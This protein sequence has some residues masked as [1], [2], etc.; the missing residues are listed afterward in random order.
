MSTFLV[1]VVEIV[2]LWLLDTAFLRVAAYL[3]ARAVYDAHKPIKISDV[4]FESISGPSF[5]PV[6]FRMS[7]VALKLVMLVCSIAIGLSI[8]GFSASQSVV[9]PEQTIVVR[10]DRQMADIGIGGFRNFSEEVLFVKRAVSCSR[11]DR[12]DRLGIR[13]TTFWNIR[14]LVPVSSRRYVLRNST[15]K[16]PVQCLTKDNN[17]NV[18]AVLT[19]NEL[20]ARASCAEKLP[21]FSEIQIGV[22]N[23]SISRCPWRLT[24]LYCQAEHRGGCAFTLDYRQHQVL[25]MVTYLNESGTSHGSIYTAWQR[26]DSKTLRMI[27]K[28][29][30]FDLSASVL[31]MEMLTSFQAGKRSIMQVEQSSL[32]TRINGSLFLPGFIVLLVIVSG[33]VVVA[34]FSHF[35]MVGKHRSDYALGL[36]VAEVARFARQKADDVQ[37]ESLYVKLHPDFPHLTVSGNAANCGSWSV[38]EV[39]RAEDEQ[40][41]DDND[42]KE[43]LSFTKYQF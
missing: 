34:V 1:L 18:S 14:S 4:P 5:G 31:E 3:N 43:E 35:I 38:D 42:L 19:Y 12:S 28:Y 15:E 32:S 8:D 24:H 22:Y 23:V 26:R 25:K 11:W 36:R 6:W 10:Q 9:V 13:N 21:S 37:G 30:D 16:T 2:A 33:F 17:Y 39:L 41:L 40:R 27:A 20:D 29:V 7:Q